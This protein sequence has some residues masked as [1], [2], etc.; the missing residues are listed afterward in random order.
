MVSIAL[1][2]KY[3]QLAAIL[4][5][6]SLLTAPARSEAT[7]EEYSVRLRAG[8]QT[9]ATDPA[10]AKRTG[11]EGAD[12]AKAKDA[13]VGGDPTGAEVLAALL[14]DEQLGKAEAVEVVATGYYAGKESTGKSPGHPAYGI[15]KSGVKVRRAN[16]STIAAD[17]MVFPIGTILRIPGYGYG[18]V[19]DTGN[20][21][22]GKKIDLYF[23][24]KDK[25]Y[26]E[27]GK[28]SVTVYVLLRGKGKV[29]EAMMDLLNSSERVSTDSEP[30][31]M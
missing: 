3:V 14:P 10:A 21:I 30:S 7:G 1:S 19:A 5:V 22:K 26:A 29:T 20:A 12:K 28:R 25:V 9:E 18:V 24:T 13:K 4:A 23:E 27:W 17:P 6:L 15:T 2:R 31:R 16:F 8:A 11:S